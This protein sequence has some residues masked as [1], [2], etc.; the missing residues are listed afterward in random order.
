ME[1]G[2]TARAAAVTVLAVVAEEEGQMEAVPLV[3]AAEVAA[4][5]AVVS[6][7][8]VAREGAA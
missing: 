3:A 8:V 6:K 5:T 7:V 1:E 4:M 2:A